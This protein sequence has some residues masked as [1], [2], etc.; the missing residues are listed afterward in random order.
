MIHPYILLRKLPLIKVF[1]FF[2]VLLSQSVTLQAQGCGCTN[3]PQFMPDNFVGD[4]LIN[5]MGADNP[6]LGQNGQGVC[7]VN[8]HLDHEYIGD[9]TIILTSPSGQSVTLIGP[10]GFFGGTDGSSWDI[11]FVPCNDPANPDPG[12][13]EQWSNN[14]N[15]G[16]NNNYFGS[17]YP[18]N[19]CLENF[20]SGPVDGTWT[21][22]VVDG[23]ANDVGNF[24][25]YEIIFCDP[26]GISCFS[27][28]A[29]AGN[30]TQANITACQGSN[31]LNLSLP[32][33]YTPPL[34][35]PPASEY[36]Y[37]YIVSGAGGVILAYDPGPDLTGYDPGVYN[38]CGLSY[39]IAQEGDI[40]PPNG[41]LTTTQLSNQLE[42]GSPPF[43]GDVS[44]DCVQVTINAA[45]DD[46]EE[47][48]EICA[49][50]CYS[51]F[52][53]NYC[54]SG[55]YVRTIT[56]P[57]GCQYTA[58]LY[59]TVHQPALTNLNEVICQDECATTEGFEG[60]CSPGLYQN[61]LQTVYGCDSLVILNLQV[62]NVMAVATPNGQLDCSIPTVQIIGAGSSTGGTV[63]YLWT[64]SNGGNIVGSNTNINVLVNEAGDYTLKVCRS[65]GGAFCCDSTTVTLTD[66]GA[67]PQPPAA[68]N[69]PSIVC[70]GDTL[71]Y[72]ATPV[73]GAVSYQWIVPAGAT[74]L[75]NATGASIQVVWNNATPG[76]VCA[77]AVN[78][79]GTS[80][81]TCLQVSVSTP[82][83]GQITHLCDSTNMNYTVSFPVSG[84]VSPYNIPGGIVTNGI[85]LSN[86]IP[87]D[88]NYLF[89]I[90]DSLGCSSDT[91]GGSFNCAC[92]TGAGQMDLSPLS[93]CEDD[94]LTAT[95]LGG[96]TL[97]GNDITAFILHSGSGTSLTPPVIAQNQTGVFSF[98]PG[99]VYGQTYYISLV[100]G[101]NLNGMP[102]LMDPCL[103]VAQGQPVVF[104][105]NPV[106][107]AGIDLDTCGLG[108]VLSGTQG[109]GTGQWT[110]LNSPTPD[111]LQF[112]NQTNPNSGVLASGYGSYTLLWTLNN[113]GCL[114]T[115]TVTLHFNASPQTLNLQYTCDAANENY[116]VSFDIN[117]GTPGYVVSGTPVGT[118]V[119][120]SFQSPPIPNNSFFNYQVVDSAGCSAAPLSGT[121][122]CLCA[123]VSGQMENT[124]LETCEGGS[125][126]AI[127]LGGQI[128]DGND[129]ALFVLHTLSGTTLGT[130]LDQNTSGIFSFTAGM[131]YGTTYYVSYVVGNVVSGAIDFQ[132]PCLS[133]SPGQ[134]VIFYE[135][136]VADAGTDQTTCGVVLGLLANQPSGSTG[137]WTINS[138]PSGGS[139]SLGNSQQAA[140]SATAN[141]FGSYML[142]WTLSLNG[143]VGTDQV[144][145][146]FNVSP[147]LDNLSRTCDAANQNFTVTLDLSGGTPPYSVNGQPVAGTT[148]T[149]T[150]LANGAVY[151]FT[152]EDANG[153]AMPNIMGAFSCDCSTN[154]GSMSAQSITVCQG[155]TATATTVGSTVLDG[156]DIT[157]F[158][159]H[160]GAGPALGQVFAQNSTGQFSF[161][162]GSMQFGVTYYI[163][164]VAGNAVAGFPDPADPCFSVAPGQPVVWLENPNPMAGPDAAICGQTIALQA[165]NSAFSGSW[166]QVSGPGTATFQN[167]SLPGST[168][169]VTTPGT[170]VFEWA[171]T[172]GN[173]SAANQVSIQFHP[174][175]QITLLNEQCDGTNTEYV[176]SFTATTG[177]APY[178]VSGLTGSFAGN[179]FTSLPLP[180]NSTYSFIL[181]DANGCESPLISGVENC[182]C[183]TNAGTMATSPAVFC[184]GTPATATWNNDATLDANDIVMFILHNGSGAAIGSTVYAVNNQP[185]FNFAPPLQAGTTYY[186]SAIAGNN[187]AGNV[188]LTDLCLSVTPGAPVQW[189]ALPDASFSGDATICA[190]GSATLSFQGTGIYPLLISYTENGA[191][192]SFLLTGPQ[193]VTIDVSPSSTS[194]YV[195]TQ[196]TDGSAPFCKSS[197]ME[198]L[199]VTVN[200]PGEAGATGPA[201]AFCAGENNT[202]F[203]FDLLLGADAG[204]TW[205]E[206]SPVPSQGN[207]FNANSGTFQ[208]GGQI[209]GTYTFTY[210]IPGLAPCAPDEASVSIFIHP[211]PNAD[212]GPDKTLNCILVSANLGGAGTTTGQ[213][214]WI[215]NGDTV[216][217]NRQLLAKE[218]GIYTLFITSVE[219]CTDEDQVTVLVDGELPVAT[220]TSV[221][222]VRC[223]NEENGSVAV[224]G[225]QSTHQPVLYSLDGVN[226]SSNPVFSGLPAGQYVITLQDANG[227]ESTTDTLL[228]IEPPALT[229]SLGP[230]LKIQLSD[231]AHVSLQSNVP[232]D[233]LDIVWKPLLDST[234]A[235]LPYQNFFP[236]QSW[237]LE[238]LVTDSSG[239]TGKDRIIIQV[240]KPYQVYIP[241]IFKPEGEL[242]PV[243]YIFAGPDVEIIESFLLFD[244]WGEAVMEHLNFLPN[245]PNYGWDGNYKGEKVNPGVFVY[246]AMVR[247]IDGERVLFKG[248]VTVVR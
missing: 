218:G 153:C 147:V 198:E 63:T 132:D 146:Q 135:N 141:G 192:N 148:F 7:G 35:E 139:L 51:F 122:A 225:I 116:Q 125:I 137:Q 174:I 165:T 247:F 1:T 32:P 67:P 171:L 120:N 57:Q 201:L 130:I 145:L 160:N 82:G 124:L 157:G 227:C 173:C 16:V 166:S 206:T 121:F 20:N 59:L 100:A 231:S 216:G 169:T 17:Y 177:Q 186:I 53:I 48:A 228:V 40:P 23:Q 90:S 187:T 223:N 43:C 232:T 189:R 126:T 175:P 86:P 233:D 56:T 113:Q 215:L 239:C 91:L 203:L 208:T 230:D 142:T 190:G 202:V 240:E 29:E 226:F 131:T 176:V 72:S 60:E 10:E 168:V 79:C 115:D 18:N 80:A 5:V 30:L 180:N 62:L 217:T 167:S 154:A 104:Y 118:A 85:F 64:A 37:T 68:I 107:N 50:G 195:L 4:F 236:L 241:N 205:T 34:V 238:V 182:D 127:H 14:Q 161:Q 234:A 151:S 78:P 204:G 191:L 71:N 83:F 133:V 95:H 200:Q 245:D 33:T 155:Q 15:W 44:D 211:K 149:S 39:L 94:T 193:T 22:T 237:Q 101:N 73:A 13:N 105:E 114:D 246:A 224:T 108:Q 143:C 102:D 242:N 24:Y 134:P 179:I 103:S 19:G 3:C 70:Q 181:A 248:D 209:P 212:A 99:M 150:P 52:N 152:V 162:P 42:G 98:Q 207:A 140:T 112:S 31:N 41:S 69:G 27:C 129:T 49:P 183:A 8:I 75:G 96:Q 219:G 61:N 123:S 110:L 136:P 164:L 77:A 111:T 229:I 222:N 243:L 2:L 21:L 74:I 138:T 159:L 81:N 235:G 185:V 199:T 128:L 158:V 109:A 172:N 213:Y 12:F 11:S 119:G 194:T 220:G 117:G 89:Q 214:R 93:A 9:L 65:G 197:L 28:A 92:F 84:G 45:P 88:S 6:T 144:V 55:T 210:L 36:G 46:I 221:R 25:D 163:S 87:N 188:D 76:Q 26:S 54:Q 38:I 66:S 47:F 184:A 178:S 97:D 156:N 58:T 170:Y 196:V 106:A 244:R